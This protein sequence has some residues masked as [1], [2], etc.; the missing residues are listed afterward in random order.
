MKLVPLGLLLTVAVTAT[1]RGVWGDEAILPAASFGVLATVIQ[2]FA[3]RALARNYHGSL[4]EL[5]RGFATGLI[6]RAGGV[7]LLLVAVLADREHFPPL[8]TAFGYLGVVIPLLFLEA[9]FIR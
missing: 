9:R 1:L 4:A 7:A 2:W 8:P 5:Y 3:G 6:L